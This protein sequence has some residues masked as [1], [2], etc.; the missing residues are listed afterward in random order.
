MCALTVDAGSWL[1]LRG[2]RLD[3]GLRLCLEYRCLPSVL[4]AGLELGPKLELGVM[5][6][7]K[8]ELCLESKAETELG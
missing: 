8:T 1:E 4:G 2:V 7:L 5:L 6:E 3:V